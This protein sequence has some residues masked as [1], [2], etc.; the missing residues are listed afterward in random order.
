ME[1]MNSADE[2]AYD[3]FISFKSENVEVVRAI[4][5]L[6]IANQL[7]VWFSEYSLDRKTY[8]GTDEMM[9]DAILA[10]ISKSKYAICF[11]NEAYFSS[12]WCR[13]ELNRF[14]QCLDSDHIIQISVPLPAFYAQAS[15]SQIEIDEIREL[16]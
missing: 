9:R 5:E 15:L 16:K 12:A 6:L 1:P 11:T 14:F 7:R 8:L 2:K 13:T 4:A 3:F 10:G